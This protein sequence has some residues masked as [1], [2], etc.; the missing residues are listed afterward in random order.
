MI[1]NG[2]RFGDTEFDTV[3]KS[4]NQSLLGTIHDPLRSKLHLTL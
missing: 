3:T 2:K 4:H 1:N